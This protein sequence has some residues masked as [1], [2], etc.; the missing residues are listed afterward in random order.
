MKTTNISTTTLSSIKDNELTPEQQ[1]ITNDEFNAIYENVKVQNKIKPDD[2]EPTFV[3]EKSE[4]RSSEVIQFLH[5]LRTKG[6]LVFLAE[7]NA[8]KIEKLVE[9]YREKLLKASDGS[10]ES[11]QE[12]AKLV[13]AYKEKLLEEMREK[14]E[15]E[16]KV[17]GKTTPVSKNSIVQ[18]FID[19]Q[20]N[21]EAKP[22]EELIKEIS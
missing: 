7:M 17:E 16:A 21:K 8:E 4:E 15:E 1:K 10:P 11:L 20:Q 19:L 14:T 9:K 13:E 3:K 5:D 2:E 18:M 12:I 6:A 22:L